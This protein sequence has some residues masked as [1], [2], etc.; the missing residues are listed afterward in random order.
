MSPRAAAYPLAGRRKQRPLSCRPESLFPTHRGQPRTPAPAL[1]LPE[2]Q[3]SKRVR[4]ESVIHRAV[5]KLVPPVALTR[6]DAVRL[7]WS[8]DVVPIALQD[9][10]ACNGFAGHEAIQRDP[11]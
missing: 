8:I 11:R 4:R 10:G 9:S 7:L 1:A 5:L 3:Y 6:F 2:P